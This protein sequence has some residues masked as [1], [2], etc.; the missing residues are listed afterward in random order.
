MGLAQPIS[1]RRSG[2]RSWGFTLA[3][4]SKLLDRV[5][6]FLGVDYDNKARMLSQLLK[7]NDEELAE[8]HAIVQ[9]GIDRRHAEAVAK[10]VA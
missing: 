3:E 8:I 10:E 6:V 7:L 1:V 2:P 9:R 5:N 4:L